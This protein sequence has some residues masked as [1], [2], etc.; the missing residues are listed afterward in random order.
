MGADTV[1]VVV[2]GACALI[3]LGGAFGVIWFRN[4]VH[5]ALSLVAT[6]FGVAVLFLNMDAPFLAAVQ[7]IVYTG[8]IVVL[9]L[10][11]IMLLGVDIE[12]DVDEE[13][14]HYQRLVALIV[15]AGVA[16]LVVAGVSVVGNDLVSGARGVTAAIVED[17]PNVTALGRLLFTDYVFALELAAVLLT[18]AVVAAVVLARRPTE[19]EPLPAEDAS[20]DPPEPVEP[21]AEEVFD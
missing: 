4:P 17:V 3:V 11:V 6:L 21:E 2:F 19:V 10:F 9:I 20:M 15:A 5:A 8:A 16:G 12:D 14:L 7:V 13:P 18:I 1:E